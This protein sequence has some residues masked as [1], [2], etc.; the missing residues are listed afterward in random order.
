M[1]VVLF[2]LVFIFV[3]PVF[4]RQG[5]IVKHDQTFMFKSKKAVNKFAVLTKNER[6]YLLEKGRTHSKIKAGNGVIGWVAN[7]DVK[8]DPPESEDAYKFQEMAVQG[9]TDNPTAIYIL[10]HTDMNADA[11]LLTRSFKNEIFEFIDR[12]TIERFN[13]EN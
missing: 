6:V 3:L 9:W 7:T 12:E 10:D 11:I 13:N 1:K 4:S 2:C 5:L 8:Y